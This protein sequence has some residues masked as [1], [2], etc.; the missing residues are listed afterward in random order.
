MRRHVRS[1]SAVLLVHALGLLLLVACNNG[2]TL[3]GAD[4]VGGSDGALFEPPVLSTLEDEIPLFQP[5][6]GAL[7]SALAA[8]DPVAAAA[9]FTAE[10]KDEYQA[11][12]AANV[13]NLPALAEVLATG[14]LGLVGETETYPPDGTSRRVG[15]LAVT[16]D[17]IVFHVLVIKVDDTWMFD[18][19]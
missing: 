16:V 8:K 18:S 17:G 14:Q 5:R 2:G 15:D 19:M 11:F 6:L 13:E 10:T 7:T 1:R 9:T 3:G 4:T 12:F